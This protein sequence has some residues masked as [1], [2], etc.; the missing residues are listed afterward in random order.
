MLGRLIAQTVI[1]G[2]ALWLAALVFDGVHFDGNLAA[3]TVTAIVFGVVNLVV[4][5]FVV[6][7]TL[8][9]TI[10][11]FGLFLPVINAM[12]L[13]L[14]GTLSRSYSVDSF[15]AALL[16]GLLVSLIDMALGLVIG[17]FRI[18]RA[19]RP[20]RPARPVSGSHPGD[21]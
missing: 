11:T 3:L 1:D 21:A 4:R 5:P 9:L 13:M 10:L 17:D 16:A 15:W 8:P 12:M 2:F 20:G 18:G 7:L 19:A 14:T 6:L